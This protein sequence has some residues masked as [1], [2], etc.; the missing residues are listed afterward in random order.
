MRIVVVSDT[1]MPRM[2]KQL[3]AHLISGLKGADLILHAGDWTE[4][5]VYEQ[6]SAYA[7]VHGIAGNNDP[8]SIVERLGYQTII[9]AAGRRFGIVHGHGT[10]GTTE[11]RAVAAFA[12]EQV[13]C[14][15]YGH[16]HIPAKSLQNGVWVFNPGSPTDRR[17]QKKYSYGIITTD[18]DGLKL[19]HHLYDSKS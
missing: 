15:I 19:T 6:L 3:P 16:S 12:G 9:E 1:H 14:I 5:S 4:W 17:R 11:G 7:P 13:D 10:R 18:Q 8:R 2:A